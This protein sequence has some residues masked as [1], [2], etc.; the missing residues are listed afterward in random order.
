MASQKTEMCLALAAAAL[1]DG[2]A[3]IT[4]DSLNN[5]ITAT[6]N[7]VEPCVRTRAH[8]YASVC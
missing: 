3:E 7:S 4:G 8:A 5:L 1:Y 6:G 2:D